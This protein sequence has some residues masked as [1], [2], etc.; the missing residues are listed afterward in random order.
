[1]PSSVSS[2]PHCHCRLRASL[3]EV[4]IA[5]LTLLVNAAIGQRLSDGGGHSQ[6][7]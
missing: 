3:L 4:V 1:M 7:A 6:A 5:S 2:Q